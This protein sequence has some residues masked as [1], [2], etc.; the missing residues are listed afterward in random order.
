VR[1][2]RDLLLASLTAGAA[3]AIIT[4]LAMA[5]GL[6]PRFTWV[7]AVVAPLVGMAM[8]RRLARRSQPATVAP[9]AP[10]APV[11]VVGSACAVCRDKILLA[12]EGQRCDECAAPL[13]LTCAPQHAC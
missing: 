9:A 3:A 12:R 6:P 5:L 2:T 11:Q 1:F 13:H 4:M 7:N 8:M 10:A